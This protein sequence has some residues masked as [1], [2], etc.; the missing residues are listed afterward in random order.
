VRRPIL[1][2]LPALACIALAGCGGGKHGAGGPPAAL[3]HPAKL[4]AQAP[5]LFTATFKTTKGTF[6]VEVHRAWAPHGADRFYNLVKA[7]FFNGDEFFRV[8]PGF[9]VQFGISPYPQVSSAWHAATIPDDP[10]VS[11]NTVGAVTFASAGPGTRTTQVFINLGSNKQ[12]DAN[13]APFGTVTKGLA[14]VRKLYS[15]YGDAPTSQQGEMETRGNAWLDKHY[16][17]LD[18]IETASVSPG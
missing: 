13:F 9:V 2:A 4:T 18:A 10:T 11:H 5:S 17:K 15:G 6:A 7:G 14:V 8:V 1:L 3:L 16:P 12:L